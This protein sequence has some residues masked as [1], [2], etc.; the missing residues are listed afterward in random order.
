MTLEPPRLAE[1]LVRWSLAPEERP[2]VLGDLAEEFAEERQHAGDRAARRWYWYQTITSVGPNVV[3]RIRNDEEK[4]VQRFLT[5]WLTGLWVVP[6]AWDYWHS[7]ISGW[8]AFG[9]YGLLLIVLGRIKPTAAQAR[10]LGRTG[11]GLLAAWLVWGLLPAPQQALEVRYL[12][13][14]LA[15]VFLSALLW[16]RWPP[17]PP[18]A[19]LF[20][21]PKPAPDQ[22]PRLLLGV[23]VPN[24][25]LGLSGLV[26]TRVT[27]GATVQAPQSTRPAVLYLEPT[28]DREFDRTMTLRFYA[29]I[30]TSA[31]PVRVTCDV[32][33]RAG[34][35]IRT[36]TPRVE[37]N[38]FERLAKPWDVKPAEATVPHIGRID[39]TLS[40]ADLVPGDYRVRLT[41]TDGTNAS[42]QEERIT[43]R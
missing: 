40:L 15:A 34:H 21:R 16:R 22:D 30:K 38:N 5:T 36:L 31:A 7:P 24:V 6:R 28:I 11:F 25:A 41:T 9:A 17:D 35:S 42:Q 10:F 29:A 37:F 20:V 2:A 33:D 27:P 12:F 18:P 1:Q 4:R 39:L 23:T 26:V 13:V 14:P 32:L 3:R 43:V 19:E 8:L